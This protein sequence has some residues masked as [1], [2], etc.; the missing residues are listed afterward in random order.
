MLYFQIHLSFY[1]RENKMI[2]NNLSLK[3][4]VDYQKAL[5][6][7]KKGLFDSAQVL[8]NGILKEFQENE[9]EIPSFI[10]HGFIYFNILVS[11]NEKFNKEKK[12]RS[13]MNIMAIIKNRE[14]KVNNFQ[15]F[16]KESEH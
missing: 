9:M 11:N 13:L 8:L 6:H 12:K 14:I 1:Q 5:I 3:N 2:Y 16:R 15:S 7:M 10:Y 4:V